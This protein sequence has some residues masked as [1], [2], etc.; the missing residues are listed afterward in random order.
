ML[1]QKGKLIVLEGID[2]SGKSTQHKLL[3]KFLRSQGKTV[4]TI[5][6]PQHGHKFFG[7]MV[8]RYLAN[9]FGPAGKLDPHLSSVWYAL[10]RWEVSHKIRDWLKKGYWVIPD[11]YTTSNLGHQTGKLMDKPAKMRKKFLDWDTEMEYLVLQIPKPDLVIHLDVDF[12]A[13]IKLLK[14]R[15]RPDGHESD[16]KYLRDSQHAYQY[17]T[18]LYPEWK[19]VI[20]SDKNGILSRDE[21]H[22]RIIKTISEIL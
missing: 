1:K 19:K 2:G 13:V 12:K 22:Q 21:I 9:E 7:V 20:C 15:G 8:D 11:R 3:V 17:V 4:K 5:H 10:D 18:K 6:F 16:I 14:A